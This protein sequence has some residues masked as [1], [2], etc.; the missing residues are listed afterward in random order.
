MEKSK[1]ILSSLAVASF[2][3]GFAINLS[4]A[5]AQ[6]DEQTQRELY[7]N[8]AR[9]DQLS[10][11]ARTLLELKFGKKDASPSQPTARSTTTDSLSPIAE[12][13]NVLVNNPNLD[14]TAQ[15]TQSETTLV[16]FGAP[17]SGSTGCSAYN[18]SGS[19]IGGAQKFTGFSR[20]TD[21]GA[22]WADKG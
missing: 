17:G 14:L 18:D 13:S 9:F 20:S 12:D 10:G 4:P 7:D 15:D 3:I 5:S 11:A 21:G 22:T 19:F 6:T 16:V 1:P 8:N 2:L